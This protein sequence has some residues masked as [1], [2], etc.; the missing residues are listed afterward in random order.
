MHIS[1]CGDLQMVKK[2]L[3]VILKVSDINKVLTVC[4]QIDYCFYN[5]SNADSVKNLHSSNFILI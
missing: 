1:S 3:M 5:M 2:V 4:P